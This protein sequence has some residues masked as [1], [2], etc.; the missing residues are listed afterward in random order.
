MSL[1]NLTDACTWLTMKTEKGGIKVAIM[2]QLDKCLKLKSVRGD[3]NDRAL[4]KVKS[5][6]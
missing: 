1:L 5:V 3:K 6:H 2:S 4:Y